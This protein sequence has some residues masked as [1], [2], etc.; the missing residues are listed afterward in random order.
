[1]IDITRFSSLKKFIIVT[2]YIIPFVNNLKGT[3]K[4]DKANVLLENTLTIHEYNNALNLC[5]KAEQEILQRQADFGKLKVSLKLF[6]DT[7][8]FLRLTCRF[9][10]AALGY[11]EKH[12]LIFRSLEN[13]FFT[14]LII[15]ESHERVLHH[16]IETTLSHVIS[17]FW[18]VKGWKAVKSVLRKC[19]TCRRYQGRPS[20]PPE[21]PDLPDYRVNTL[22][23]FQCT[24]RNYAGPLFIKHNRDT[25]LKVYILPFKCVSNCALSL[26][27]T[28]DMKALAFIKAFERF[29]A[30]RGT[31]DVVI[32][33]NF[34]SF[35]LSVVKKFMLRFGV[36]QKFTLPASP[37]WGGFYERLVRSVK[38]VLTKIFGK[39][40]LSYEKL[41]TV[42]LKIESVI[43]GRPLAF[44]SEDDL[45]DTLTPNHLMYARNIRTKSNAAVPESIV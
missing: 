34:K 8:E 40:L 37:W 1:M 12:P 3:L 16:G 21:T 4:N 27:L 25:T 30:R 18:I 9:E 29:M 24:G 11:D 44:L 20:L 28:P 41:E 45:G 5:R 6:V 23:A 42:L 26:E 39:S 10:N 31:P 43:N 22:H 32:S 13:T 38:M 2:G 19:V 35:K 15:L 33:D 7:L 17:T 36:Q 14:K